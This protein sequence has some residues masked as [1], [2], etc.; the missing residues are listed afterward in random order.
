MG[1]SMTAIR[2]TRI[3]KIDIVEFTWQQGQEYKIL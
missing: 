1:K 2:I 3:I